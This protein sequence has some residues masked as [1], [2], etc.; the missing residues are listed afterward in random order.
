MVIVHEPSLRLQCAFVDEVVA[1]TAV[2]CV[3]VYEP[4]LVQMPSVHVTV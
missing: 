4:V 3:I 2:G 1:V